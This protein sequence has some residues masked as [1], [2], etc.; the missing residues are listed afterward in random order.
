MV[1]FLDTN[2]TKAVSGIGFLLTGSNFESG[3]FY[4]LDDGATELLF[5]FGRKDLLKAIAKS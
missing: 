3:K 1:T 4:L 2:E 5:F